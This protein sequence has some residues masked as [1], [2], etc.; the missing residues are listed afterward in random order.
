MELPKR[1]YCCKIVGKNT[2]LTAVE[3]RQISLPPFSIFI[4]LYTI[5]FMLK[6]N[7]TMNSCLK[8]LCSKQTTL[9]RNPIPN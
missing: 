4:D 7:N 5:T 1:S 3:D 8:A 2:R 9:V 6:D